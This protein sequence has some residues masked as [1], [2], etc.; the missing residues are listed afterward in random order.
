MPFYIA[1]VPVVHFFTGPHLDYHRTTDT[2]DKI[3]ATGGVQIANVIAMVARTSL[4]TDFH[5][6]RASAKPSM[7]LISA[8]GGKST[9]AYLGTIPDYSKLTSPHGPGEGKTPEGG[10]A[11]SGVRPGSPAAV[12]G[13]TAGD[14]LLGITDPIGAL[15]RIHTL[16]EF[17][18]ALVTLHP[19]DHVGLRVL[20]NGQELVAPTV[21]GKR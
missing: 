8:P 21:V 11:L 6:V 14:I 7:G 4:K 18:H 3:N 9:G 15:H 10:V 13:I 1:K 19:G 17:M 5:F 20:R 16:E 2:A 12:A